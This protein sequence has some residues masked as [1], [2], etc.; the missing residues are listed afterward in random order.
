MMEMLDMETADALRALRKAEEGVEPPC[1]LCQRSRVTR[2]DYIRCN[3]CGVN[4]LDGEDIS[5]DP[6]I[7]RKRAWLLTQGIGPTKTPSTSGAQIAE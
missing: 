3:P 2:S 6:R 7:E 4:W 5:K 1:P